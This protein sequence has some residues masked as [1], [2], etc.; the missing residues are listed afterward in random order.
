MSRISVVAAIVDEQRITLYKPDG[1]TLVISQGDP[2]VRRIIDEVLPLVDQGRE[3]SIDLDMP[4]AYDDFEKKGNGLVRFF[5]VAKKAVAHIFAAPSSDVTIEPGMHG[6]VPAKL[7]DRIAAEPTSK[8]AAVEEIVANAQPASAAGFDDMATNDDETMIAVVGDTVIPGVEVLKEQLRY[9]ANLGS[10]TGM[11]NFFKRI[12]PVIGDRKHSVQDILTFM[13]KNDLP[14]ADDGS[15]LVYKVLRKENGVYVDCHTRRVKQRIGSFVCVDPALI[16]TNRRNECSAGLHVARRG[17]IAGF[18][19]DCCTLVKVAPED[20]YVVPHGDPNKVR[21]RGYHIL[22][23]LSNDA[24]AKLKRNTPMTSNPEA[25]KLLGRAMKG[26]HPRR[27]E[28]VLIT[29][30]QGQGVVTTALNEKGE[31][32]KVKA[33]AATA[34]DDK[35]SPAAPKVDPRSVDA[36]VAQRVSAKPSVPAAPAKSKPMLSG[37]QQKARDLYE[38]VATASDPATRKKAAQDLLAF[39]KK[40]KVSWEALGILD[41]EASNA[42]AESV[43]EAPT[44]LETAKKVTAKA[45]RIQAPKVV[46]TAPKPAPEPTEPVVAAPISQ[47]TNRKTRLYDLN[48]VYTQS[49]DHAHKVAAAR[50]LLAIRK[51]AKKSWSGLGYPELN[52]K[53]LQDFVNRPAPAPKVE[54][55]VP[56]P[57]AIGPTNGNNRQETARNYFKTNDYANLWEL[58]RRAKVSWEKLGFNGNEISIIEANRPK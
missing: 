26:D 15:L 31:R 50:E 27:I 34:L 17:Y 53:L 33:G 30:Q 21:V 38:I 14:I 29:G 37:R 43:K 44:Q 52:D 46:K 42:L 24:W 3:A 19:G 36:Q 16:D 4:N 32:I 22:F 48:K 45:P 10:T 41:V 11:E 28:E 9:S 18:G 39:K 25:A 1:S 51:A 35:A 56:A 55:S 7:Q 47:G 6:V 8:L 2:R 58:K 49:E 13:E 54:A 23:E 40:A 57:K 12:A 20:V 5:R